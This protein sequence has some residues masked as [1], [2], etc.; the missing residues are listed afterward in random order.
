[1][2]L[3]F[4]KIY[5]LLILLALTACGAYVSSSSVYHTVKQGQTLYTISKVYGVDEI[6]LARINK[7]SDPTQLRVGSRIYIPGAAGTKNV[8]ATVF[9]Q[10][11]PET[12]TTTKSAVIPRVQKTPPVKNLPKPTRQKNTTRSAPVQ[13]TPIAKGSFIWPV[14]GQ[15]VKK[16]N[17]HSPVGSKGVEISVSSGT[18]VSS[19]AAGKVIY[20]GD[21]ITGYGNLLIVRHDDS[22]F[23][24]YG[25]NKKNLVQTGAFVSKGEKIALSGQPPSG[26]VPRVY[27]EIRYGK[28][29]VDPV[30]YLP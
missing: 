15:M 21:G 7:I 17:T 23:T 4:K 3:F 24:V 14:K 25:Y 30:T 5:L 12:K 1:M 6:Y 9:N 29:P 8:P 18:P 26:G 16:F 22:F 2:H 11:P 20:S 13:K 28:K 19:A 10:E 27:F